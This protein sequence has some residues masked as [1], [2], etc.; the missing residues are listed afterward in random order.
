VAWATAVDGELMRLI[1]RVPDE[2]PDCFDNI[3]KALF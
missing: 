1:I 2:S 3:A